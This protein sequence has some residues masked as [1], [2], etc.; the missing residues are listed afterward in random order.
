MTSA[1]V[2][3]ISMSIVYKARDANDTKK[4]TGRRRGVG[5]NSVYSI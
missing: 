3:A 1:E 5:G 2:A 4:T